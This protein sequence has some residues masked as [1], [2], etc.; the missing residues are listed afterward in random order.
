MTQ[1]E[2]DIPALQVGGWT[3]GL[4]LHLVQNFTVTQPQRVEPD[5]LLKYRKLME[6]AEFHPGM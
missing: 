3:W 4:W 1:T 6:D 5:S 2:R